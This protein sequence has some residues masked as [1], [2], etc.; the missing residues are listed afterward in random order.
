MR[1]IIKSLSI[2]SMQLHSTCL[3]SDMDY[4]GMDFGD[5]F[6]LHDWS[7][8]YYLFCLAVAFTF[9]LFI[10]TRDYKEYRRNPRR[11]EEELKELFVQLLVY[12]VF[13]PILALVGWCIT[14]MEYVAP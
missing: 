13:T 5:Y 10:G 8:K 12:L 6:G 2:Y 11:G 1:A 9:F 3:V 4:G 7:L 14:S